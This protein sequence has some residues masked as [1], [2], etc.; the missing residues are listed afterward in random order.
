MQKDKAQGVIVSI[1][2]HALIGHLNHS[3]NFNPQHVADAIIDKVNFEKS[4]DTIKHELLIMLI[5]Q[6]KTRAEKEIND[7][8][9][10]EKLLRN[11]IH[12]KITTYQ[13]ILSIL[14][15]KV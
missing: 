11:F 3:S 10:D 14:T 9:L 15:D 8:S 4:Y 2:Q 13:E 12:G 5:Q 6:L 1:L 7:L